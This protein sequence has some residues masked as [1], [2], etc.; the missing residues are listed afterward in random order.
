[1]TKKKKRCL[2]LF[3]GGGTGGHLYPALAIGER[4]KHYKPDCDIRFVGTKRGIENKVIPQK[5]YVLYHIAVRGFRRKLTLA[6]VT[7]PA[8]L[9]LS[10]LQCLFLLLRHRPSV[11][12]GTG[13]YVSGPV[14]FVA[15]LLRIPTVI[16][17]QNSYPGVTTRL[18]A[19]TA[20]IVHLS[21]SESIRYFKKRDNIRITGNPVRRFDLAI[22]KQEARTAFGLEPDKLTLFVF[23]GS[24]GAAAIN[25][26]ILEI[27][28][29]LLSDERIQL[30]W[31]TGAGN[32]APVEKEIEK[33]VRRMRAFEFISDMENAYAATDLAVCRAGAMTLAELTVC[34]VPSILIPYPYAAANHQEA[35]ARSLEQKGAARVLVERDLTPEKLYQLIIEIIT[36]EEKRQKMAAKARA[37]AF[38]NATDEIATS[39]LELMG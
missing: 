30:L 27:V 5:G 34:G 3:A 33:Y 10:L 6:T 4:I 2:V 19:R 15:G 31:S 26:A 13:G 36:S 25:N 7:I 23:G 8:Y 17:E 32:L 14:L 35:N 18:L 1:M 21:F 11:V 24:Q 22:A 16:Q 37:A 12:V 28:D 29:R 20:R 9:F 38:P 39:V